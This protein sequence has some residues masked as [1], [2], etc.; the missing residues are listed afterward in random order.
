M[1]KIRKMGSFKQILTML[2]GIPKEIR[3]VDIDEK[4]LDKT[5][6]IVTSITKQNLKSRNI[7]STSTAFRH[8]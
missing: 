5:N 7:Q 6:A 4:K 2:P 8:V 3:D 1:K